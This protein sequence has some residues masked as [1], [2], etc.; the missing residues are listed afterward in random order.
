MAQQWKGPLP[1]G[2][3]MP[4]TPR[5]AAIVR[6][7]FDVVV[8][9]NELKMFWSHPDPLSYDFGLGDGLV[10][11]ARDHGKTVRGHTLVFGDALADWIGQLPFSLFPAGRALLRIPNL[12]LDKI[13][14]PDF[15]WTRQL[16]LAVMRDFITRTVSHY[17]THFPG[18]VPE[19]DVVN[20]AFD[21]EGHYND[22][23]FLRVIGP[24]YIAKAFEYAHAAD[25]HALLFYNE[26]DAQEP[27]ARQRAVA[28]MAADFKRRGVPIDGIGIQVHVSATDYPTSAQLRRVMRE[29]RKLGLRVE[30]SE[31]D[32]S[33]PPT[34][35]GLERQARAY[36]SIVGDCRAA[37]N[38]T[39]ITVWG[40]ADPYS[41]RG[42]AA[43][44]LLYDDA[45]KAKPFFPALREMLRAPPA[46]ALPAVAATAPR[47]QRSRS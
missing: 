2:C 5:Y 26:Y 23:L 34:R 8:P 36:R 12:G 47:R 15:L 30:V 9:E 42:D 24:D 13:I 31:L 20:E 3:P 37:P 43:E 6:N 16:G 21:D 46:V 4:Y 32:V 35:Y 45:L 22:N 7:S 41:W 39:G 29:Y 14:P 25:P 44:P 28:A 17:A 33:A 1:L 38:C 19:W 27:N 40:V 11:W 18:V 10:A